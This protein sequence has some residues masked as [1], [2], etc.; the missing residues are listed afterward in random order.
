MAALHVLLVLA[1]VA[2]F[3]GAGG[4]TC[5]GWRGRCKKLTADNTDRS[6]FRA[7]L[8]RVWILR[9]VFRGGGTLY[10][11]EFLGN[12]KRPTCGTVLLQP[13][14][15]NVGLTA[16]LADVNAADASDSSGT[17]GSLVPG[18]SFFLSFQAAVRAIRGTGA[19]YKLNTAGL[20]GVGD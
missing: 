1:A 17:L 14:G 16:A 9:A 15:N 13:A 8:F 7:V 19:A 12:N 10:R 11:G 4:G 3:F 18:V 5:I 2:E 20:A 6:I